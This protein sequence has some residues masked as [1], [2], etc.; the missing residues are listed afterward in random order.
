MA[1]TITGDASQVT[2]PT[3]KNVSA[4]T[5]ASPIVITTTV[6]H[7]FATG[8]RVVISGVGGNTAANGSWT[9]TK[10][11]STTFSLNGS[12]GSGAY[13]SGGTAKNYSLTP[14][15]QIPDDGD[16]IDAA[17][18][19]AAFE[20]LAD[21]TQFLKAIADGLGLRIK[22]FTAGT[23][24]TAPANVAGVAFLYG[25]GGGGAGG[26]GPAGTTAANR[27][28]SGGGG[29]GAAQ[30]SVYPITVTG[31]QTYTIAIG[32]GGATAAADGGDTTWS[33]GGGVVKTFR[34]AGGGVSGVN[35]L[36]SDISSSATQVF[37]WS[38]GGQP[39]RGLTAQN[40]SLTGA[41]PPD[42]SVPRSRSAAGCGG[43]GAGQWPLVPGAAP[44]AFAKAGASHKNGYAGGAA[45]ASGTMSGSTRVAGGGGGGG[46]AGPGG[47]GGA[48]G[49]GGDGNSTT[50]TAGTAGG[51]AAANSGAGGG[52]GG[53]GG[54]GPNG[55]A[56]GAF[57]A[58][59]SGKLILIYFGDPT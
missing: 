13:T 21:R 31:G 55:P 12:S 25:Y 23:T 27:D 37:S 7:Q 46:A 38:E 49:T 10:A 34:G 41:Y 53:A 58:G 2:T 59:G 32:S 54:C 8:D 50:A 36:V 52:G 30:D 43:I 42:G 48:G 18:V 11:T 40:V 1:T 33:D 14:Q 9:I 56:G 20:A 51:A 3:S 35:G 47:A 22:T 19:N 15:F 16:T 24:W 26:A 45:G 28:Q 5:N 44:S 57:G 17:S 4:A 39:V 29:G 6:A